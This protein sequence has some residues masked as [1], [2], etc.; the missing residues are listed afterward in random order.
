MQQHMLSEMLSG[1]AHVVKH[2]QT[3][4]GTGAAPHASRMHACCART[5]EIHEVV[6][7][8]PVQ[9]PPSNQNN[10]HKNGCACKEIPSGNQKNE[11]CLLHAC[12]HAPHVALV[13]GWLLLAGSHQVLSGGLAALHAARA[14]PGDACV[15]AILKPDVV[16]GHPLHLAAENALDRNPAGACARRRGLSGHRAARACRAHYWGQI[17]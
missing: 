15:A 12:M 7:P 13:V 11:S 17:V 9:R 1:V 10:Q 3:E 8:E 14:L 2:I 5:Q 6:P 4:R 16:L